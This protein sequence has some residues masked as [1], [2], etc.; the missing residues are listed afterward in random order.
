M[1]EHLCDAFFEMSCPQKEL[2]TVFSQ[3]KEVSLDNE[4][5]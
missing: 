3:I 4:G 5:K 1:N 2:G